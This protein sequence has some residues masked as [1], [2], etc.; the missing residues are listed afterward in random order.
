MCKK[1]Y[2]QSMRGTLGWKDPD[3]LID[4]D[5]VR[6]PRDLPILPKAVTHR[7]DMWAVVMPYPSFDGSQPCAENPDL[8]DEDSDTPNSKGL[9]LAAC[10]RCPFRVSCFEWG[11]AHEEYGTF[12]GAND[13]TRD[14]L[15]KK[16]RQRLVTPQTGG[17]TFPDR[18]WDEVLKPRIWTAMDDE[19]EDWYGIPM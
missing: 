15:R 17:D 14:K 19:E 12:G 2:G 6:G 16:R 3:P 9:R 1:H 4:D 7:D 11:M 5:Q 10:K 18:N 13:S 8:W